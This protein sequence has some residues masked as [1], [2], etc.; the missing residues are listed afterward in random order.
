MKIYLPIFLT[1]FLCSF[2]IAQCQCPNCTGSM[3]ISE[4]NI[5]VNSAVQGRKSAHCVEG[6]DLKNGNTRAVN[7]DKQTAA[8]K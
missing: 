8:V 4:Y 6:M 7:A 5:G 1:F 2:A 3:W